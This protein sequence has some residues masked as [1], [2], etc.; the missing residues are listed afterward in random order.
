M[1]DPDYTRIA[2]LAVQLESA[3]LVSHRGHVQRW[4]CPLCNDEM[5]EHFRSTHERICAWLG[6]RER[7]QLDAFLQDLLQ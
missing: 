4:T 3:P 1:S 2:E 7:I 5:C 6:A